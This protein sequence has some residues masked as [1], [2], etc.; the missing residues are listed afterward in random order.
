[1]VLG[2]RAGENGF[3]QG[4][5]RLLEDLAH[6]IGAAA[7]SV[8]M[9]DEAIRLSVDLQRSRGRLVE[10][11]EEERRR[12]RRDLHDGL[13]PRLSGQALT[14]DAIRALMR[15]DP[16][17]AEELLL[18]LKAD[19]QNAVADIRRLVYGLR[20]PALDD[21]GFLR[22]LRETAEQFTIK[23]LSVSVEAPETLPPLSAA[24][25]VAAYR[26]AQE[27]LTNVSR[28]AGARNCT[29]LLAVDDPGALCL[30]IRDDGTG[31][32]GVRASSSEH[33]GVGLTSMRERADELGGGLLVESPPGGGTLVRAV[34]PLSKEE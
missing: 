11:R 19:A 4:E 20:P 1:M 25:E 23:G 24:V 12:L 33:A 21:L 16:D 14:I 29:V 10:A 6:Q 9:T 15:R 22:A 2:S 17:T 26:I 32:A 13:G 30:E 8:L 18:E 7:H 5:R 3:T 31:I 28:H 27:A 34:V